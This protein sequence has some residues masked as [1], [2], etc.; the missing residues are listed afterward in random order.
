MNSDRIEGKNPSAPF[1]RY[2]THK[3]WSFKW[4]EQRTDALGG[5]TIIFHKKKA[6]REPSII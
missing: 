3:K 1:T 4:R 6:K 5:R 2:C